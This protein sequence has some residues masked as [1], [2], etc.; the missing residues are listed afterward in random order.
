MEAG[1][2]QSI[3]LKQQII[4]NS[5]ICIVLVYGI[6]C[7]ILINGIS[8]FNGYYLLVFY[9]KLVYSGFLSP[10]DSPSSK[11]AVSKEAAEVSTEIK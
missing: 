8:I 9:F 6:Q 7:C 5:I 11:P 1:L 10:Y 4:A 2:W 3:H